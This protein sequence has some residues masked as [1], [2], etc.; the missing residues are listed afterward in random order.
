MTRQDRNARAFLS[1]LAGL[2]VLAAMLAISGC[3]TTQDRGSA[4]REAQDARSAASRWG[5]GEGAWSMV[6]PEYREAPPMTTLASERYKQVGIT[7]YR[8]H[9]ASVGDGTATR[10]IE[11]GVVNRHTQQARQARYVERWRYDA[12]RGTWWVTS[13]L[14]DLWQD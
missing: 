12:A 4:L 3:A 9:G 8:D 7:A 13:G 5:H 14:P 10:Q 11:L 2:A 1:A 6:D